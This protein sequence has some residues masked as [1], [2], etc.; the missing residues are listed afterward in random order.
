MNAP[1]ALPTS[2]PNTAGRAAWVCLAI[3]WV[4]FLVPIPGIGLFI[5]WPLNL[6][7]FILAIV[8]MSKRGAFAGLWQLLASLIASPIVYF[9][10]VAIFAGTVGALGAAGEGKY[11]ADAHSPAAEVSSAEAADRIAVEAGT[12]HKAY[13][14]NEIAADQLYKGKPLKVSGTIADIT[15]DVSDEPVL[16][17]RVSDFESVHATGLTKDVAATL[18][19]GQSIT[20][21]CVGAG[22]V[23]GTP[24]LNDCEL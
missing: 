3:A 17:L 7:A 9:V 18:A 14:A 16:S 6:V 5:G 12:L 13:A 11:A 23:I 10:G 2:I 4:T 20:V 19:K 1:A 21:S 22:E 15:S 8:A 24:L